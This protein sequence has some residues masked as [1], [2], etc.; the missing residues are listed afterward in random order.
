[1]ER[2]EVSGVILCLFCLLLFRFYHLYV[3]DQFE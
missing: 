2:E 1:L 3:W